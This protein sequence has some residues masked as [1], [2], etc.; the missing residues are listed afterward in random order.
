MKTMHH[1][2]AKHHLGEAAKHHEKAKKHMEMA[3]KSDG[4]HRDAKE[5]MSMLK[6]KIKKSCMK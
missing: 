2:K 3:K 6:S 5:D 1:E 4:K